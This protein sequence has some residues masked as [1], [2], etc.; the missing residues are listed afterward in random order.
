VAI[1]SRPTNDVYDTV[2]SVR[3]NLATTRCTHLR[4]TVRIVMCRLAFLSNN[5]SQ[6]GERCD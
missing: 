4:H 5:T 3:S 6:H 2:S 1:T